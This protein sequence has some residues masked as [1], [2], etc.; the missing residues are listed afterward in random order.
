MRS[1]LTSLFTIHPFAACGRPR[2]VPVGAPQM[3]GAPE[4]LN[5]WLEKREMVTMGNIYRRS[6][7]CKRKNV[8]ESEF[9]AH[10]TALRTGFVWRVFEK[11]VVSLMICF[12]AAGCVIM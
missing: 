5:V 6:R 12:I 11:T 2:F 10:S 8:P 4:S 7:W 9:L 1:F 3:A